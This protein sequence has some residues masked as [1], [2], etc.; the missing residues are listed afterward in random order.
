M[1]VIINIL[2]MALSHLGPDS[3]KTAV[4]LLKRMLPHIAADAAQLGQSTEGNHRLTC[5]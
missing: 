5:H 2:T 1:Q 3:R 4:Q